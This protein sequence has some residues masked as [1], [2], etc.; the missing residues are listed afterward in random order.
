MI[1]QRTPEE[2]KANT[3]GFYNDKMY[4]RLANGK[5]YTFTGTEIT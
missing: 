1:K 4:V 3:V 2:L 5:L